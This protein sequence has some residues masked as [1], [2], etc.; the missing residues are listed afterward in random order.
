[1]WFVAE[2]VGFK[3]LKTSQNLQKKTL[4]NPKFLITQF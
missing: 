2:N 4:N 1:M 3:V